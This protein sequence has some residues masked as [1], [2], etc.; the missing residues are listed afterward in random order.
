[1]DRPLRRT[2]QRYGVRSHVL[3]VTTT[4]KRR[5]GGGSAGGSVSYPLGS[6][7]GHHAHYGD[8]CPGMHPPNGL[9]FGKITGR[10]WVP[11]FSRGTADV[12]SV[13]QTFIINTDG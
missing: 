10:I 3:Q 6:V 5:A 9:L 1:M 13:Q 7:A 2:E 4:S 8:C 11:Q 12:G